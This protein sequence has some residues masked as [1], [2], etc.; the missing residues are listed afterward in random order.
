M[1]IDLINYLGFFLDIRKISFQS[2]FGLTPTI[3]STAQI[4][5]KIL[6]INFIS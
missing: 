3:L 6:I 1:Q 2:I 5:M 4:L